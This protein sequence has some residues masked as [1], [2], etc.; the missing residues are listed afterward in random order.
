M[1][2]PKDILM[3]DFEGRNKPIQI[4]AVLLDKDT[5]VEK[6]SFSS[7]IYADMLTVSTKS[8]ITQ[9]ML[10]DTPSQAEVGAMLIEKFG[11]NFLIGSWVANMDTQHFR[12]LIDAAGYT[13]DQFDFHVVDVWPAAY[14]HLVK[15]GYKGSI[16]SEEM[17]QAFGA[18]PRGLHDALEDARI[19]A[20]I[21]RQLCVFS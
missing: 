13:W 20:D 2:F 19:A 1:Y 8:G 11:M 15:K 21:L 7:Y 9:E 3:I 4:G 14:I 17:F 10:K 5:L 16:F 18:Q 12:T 6:E